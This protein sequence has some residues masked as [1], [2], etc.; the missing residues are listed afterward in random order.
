MATRMKEAPLPPPPAHVSSSVVD[1]VGDWIRQGTEGFIATQKILL[2]LAAQQ[3][4]LAL[5]IVRERLGLFSPTLSKNATN[6]VGK[7]AHNLF[8]AQQA[9]LDLLAR[10]NQ[11]V[12]DGLKPG[13]AG[14][15]AESIADLIHRGLNNFINTQK[16]FWKI[17]E[18][19]TDGTIKDFGDRKGFKLERI[20]EL[21]RDEMRNLLDSQKKFLTI[22]EEE[23][24]ARRKR[25]AED[26]PEKGKGVD[27]FEMTKESI[28]A[29]V[30]AQQQLLDLAASQVDVNVKLVREVLNPERDKRKTTALPDLMKKSVDSFVAAQKALVE[31]ASKPRH[32]AEEMATT[33]GAKG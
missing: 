31:V 25:A 13:I 33:A 24:F 30:H 12:S 15:P 5:T 20:P 26:Y 17:L 14:T 10:Q 22:V 28:D 29:F 8:G 27:V 21:A 32:A 11:I 19:E 23:L 6:L 9:L 1:L 2:D 16:E 4:A 3:N 18:E 7:G